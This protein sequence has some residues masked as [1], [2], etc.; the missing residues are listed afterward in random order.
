MR[1]QQ[2]M[3]RSVKP[4]A[5]AGLAMTSA[6]AASVSPPAPD[7]LD[8]A[9]AQEAL[10]GQS[11]FF[12]DIQANGYSPTN[13]QQLPTSGSVGYQ[14]FVQFATAE[15]AFAPADDALFAIGR[16]DMTASFD[17]AGSISGTAGNFIDGNDNQMTGEMTISAD[18][19]DP[20]SFGVGFTGL[21]QGQITSADNFEFNYQVP[22]GGIFLGPNADYVEAGGFGDFTNNDTGE[23]TPF[24]VGIIAQR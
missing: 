2:L 12:D 10:A 22:M 3:S 6:C 18:S 21:L 20:G 23:V 14:G 4:L 13:I 19:L 1:I 7:P 16:L 24:E 9:T 15:Q 17:N 5:V 8:F 11:A